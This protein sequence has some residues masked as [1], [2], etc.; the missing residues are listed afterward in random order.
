M[1]TFDEARTLIR[2]EVQRDWPPEYGELM[3]ADYGYHDEQAW[4]VVW[5]AREAL[6]D[7]NFDFVIMDAPVFFVDKVTGEI[8]EEP[9]IEVLD[10][11]DAMEPV[12]TPPTDGVSGAS[13]R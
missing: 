9:M 1:V 8:T 6:V 10:R 13:S 11:L 3:V 12:G 5:G 7:N 4:F 2:A